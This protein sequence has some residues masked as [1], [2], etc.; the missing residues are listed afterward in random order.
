MATEPVF[1]STNLRVDD[2][3][4]SAGPSPAGPAASSSNCARFNAGPDAEHAAEFY[5]SIYCSANGDPGRV[6][7]AD[8]HACPIVVEWLNAHAPVL[9]RPG[10]RAVVVGCGLGDDLIE[11]AERGYDVL[12]FDIS[13]TAVRWAARRHPGHAER[14][15]TADLLNPHPR[16]VRRF[17]LVIE[18][19]TL[20]SIPPALRTQAAR[21]LE[22]LMAPRGVLLATCRARDE[23]TSLDDLVSP[24]YP[25]TAEELLA[26]T[27]A[28]GLTA[29]NSDAAVV[30]C[31]D[32]R[33]SGCR[34]LRG[35]FVRA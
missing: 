2:T 29:M 10:C 24:P 27:N 23:Q 35:V 12:G 4:M 22:A 21:S 11:L 1:S 31:P 20:Q 30:E 15:I 6:P 13:P 7:W 9:V 5:E 28:A 25:L 18:A 17:D 8:C 16:L 32:P 34:H 26:A 3:D 14:F 33:R 19:Y